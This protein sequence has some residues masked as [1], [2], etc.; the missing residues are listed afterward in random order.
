VVRVPLSNF[1]DL[2]GGRVELWSADGA[3]M[4]SSIETQET[5]GSVIF[6]YA[7]PV[8]DPLEKTWKTHLLG[9][10]QEAQASSALSRWALPLTENGGS[11]LHQS[12]KLTALFKVN[13]TILSCADFVVGGD[14]I[15]DVPLKKGTTSC[16]SFSE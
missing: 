10:L 5:R 4:I 6:G 8:P 16:E 3:K 2:V 11:E 9:L 15:M 14:K 13:D 7:R 12:M 1:P